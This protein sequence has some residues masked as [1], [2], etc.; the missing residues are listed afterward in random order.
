[1]VSLTNTMMQVGET[2][3]LQTSSDGHYRVVELLLKAGA[4]P[5]RK[6]K[7]R[8]REESGV[9]TCVHIINNLFITLLY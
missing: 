4:N 8:M 7:V 2:A 3:L 5:D 1:M 9:N 6:D